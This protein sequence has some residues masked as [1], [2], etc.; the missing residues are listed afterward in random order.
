MAVW[1]G[2]SG[3]IRLL[4]SAGGQ[5][6][7]ARI[8][9]S[10]IDT[11][12]RRFGFDRPVTS[13]ITGDA[14]WIRRVD[15]QGQVTSG[16]LDFVAPSGWGDG[17]RHA[18]GRWYAN[19]D[20]VGGIRLFKDWGDAIT[21]DASK[22]AALTV[23]SAGYRVSVEITN[24]NDSML[25]Q[26][27]SYEL[28]TNRDVADL[29]SLGDG[30]KQQMG[31]LVSGSGTVD[32]LWDYEARNCD[33]LIESNPSVEMPNY[34]HQLVLRQEIGSRFKGIFL[35]KTGGTQPLQPLLSKQGQKR[36]LFYE[37]DCVITEVGVSIEASEAIHSKINFVTA[38]PILLR[39]EVV[40]EYL[41][42]E[43][44]VIDRILSEDGLPLQLEAST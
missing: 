39:F 36:E 9:P 12:N 13:L 25:G 10:D 42:Q 37:C 20:P 1:L 6:I 19:I 21:G 22:A 41:L 16:L 31:T 14:I 4:R 34:L 44:G 38:G 17:Q 18:D 33:P 3:G 2:S 35:L 29:S 7:Y 26:V 15:E 5:R 11:G 23:P 27:L 8:Q 43:Q 24:S 30:F 40:S 32:C 28:N